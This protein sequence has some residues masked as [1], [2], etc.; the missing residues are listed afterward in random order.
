M[1]GAKAVMAKKIL[2]AVV[3]RS[4]LSQDKRDAHFFFHH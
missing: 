1:V 2:V 3:D 4:L